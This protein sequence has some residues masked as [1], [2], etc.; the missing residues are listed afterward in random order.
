MNT[1]KTIKIE[2]IWSD[3]N[4]R[5]MHI[6]Y[7]EQHKICGMSFMQGD[8][9]EI[10]KTKYAENDPGLFEFYETMLYTFPIESKSVNTIEFINKVMWAYCQADQIRAKY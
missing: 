7:N 2:H 8:E 6:E 10:F 3:K 5:W 9:Y 1:M 4:D